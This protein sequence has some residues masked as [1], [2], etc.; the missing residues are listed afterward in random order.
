MIETE[1]RLLEQLIDL[2][3]VATIKAIISSQPVA[4]DIGQA[5]ATVRQELLT[6]PQPE[7]V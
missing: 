3:T 5:I 4:P 1:L 7:D 6:Q 2:K